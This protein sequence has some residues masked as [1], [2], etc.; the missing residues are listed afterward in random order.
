MRWLKLKS[1][2]G[3]RCDTVRYDPSSVSSGMQCSYFKYVYFLVECVR[4][5]ILL[6]FV[7]R[8][9]LT[10]YNSRDKLQVYCVNRAGEEVLYLLVNLLMVNINRAGYS[11][12]RWILI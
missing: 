8:D 10:N 1:N 6:Y 11:A 9:Q 12:V 5:M 4:T 3:I 2:T 7:K